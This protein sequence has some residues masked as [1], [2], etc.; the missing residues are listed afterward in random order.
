M[1]NNYP[2][3]KG[4]HPVHVSWYAAIAA[5]TVGGQAFTDR[6]SAWEK[7]SRGGLVFKKYPWVDSIGSKQ[8]ELRW[9]RW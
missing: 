1:R 9:N 5:Y 4:D 6:W 7:A 2:E 8:G 3:G